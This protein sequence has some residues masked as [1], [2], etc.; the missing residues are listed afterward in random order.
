M[1]DW[2]GTPT[3]LAQG[4]SVNMPQT[5]NGSMI[6]MAANMSQGNDAG[7][8]EIQTGGARPTNLNLPAGANQFVPVVHNWEAQNLKL[9]NMSVKN[10]VNIYVAAYGPGLNPPSCTP[11]DVGTPTQLSMSN[12]ASGTAVPEWMTLRFFAPSGNTTMFG[13]IG[14][15]VQGGINAYTFALNTGADVPPKPPGVPV[16]EGFY[17][18]AAGNRID[19]QFNWGSSSI[20]VVNL[21]S[22]EAAPGQVT[23]TS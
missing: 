17:Q 11:L 21:S 6:L 12:C 20:W 7:T 5:T 3:T 22:M 13:L 15:P 1:S 19:F 8:L 14:G 18:Q 9:T 4:D 10:S 23:L 16:A 2:D